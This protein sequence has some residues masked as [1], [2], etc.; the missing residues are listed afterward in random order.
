MEGEGRVPASEH[1]LGGDMGGACFWEELRLGRA[2][3][4]STGTQRHSQGSG[5]AG[6]EQQMTP[7]LTPKGKEAVLEELWFGKRLWEER[8]EE[9]D[10]RVLHWGEME[11]HRPEKSRCS[12]FC[13][14]AAGCGTG[15]DGCL[16]A[17][18]LKQGWSHLSWAQVRHCD[19]TR[20]QPGG[21]RPAQKATAG[22]R[23]GLHDSTRRRPGSGHPAQR[24][25]PAWRWD[26]A[27]AAGGGLAVGVQL[28][29]HRWPE[30]GHFTCCTRERGGWGAGK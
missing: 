14:I 11:N 13:C 30:D 10:K 12:A 29:G 27:T 21:R 28:R 26:T 2:E 9:G 19:S 23:T 3:G 4:W 16:T 20:R 24:S 15:A 7:F 8:S 25:P 22:L 1:S 18:S 5:M 6:G 17:S